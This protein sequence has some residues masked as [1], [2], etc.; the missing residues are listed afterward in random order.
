[1]RGFFDVGQLRDFDE[2][3]GLGPGPYRA[4]YRS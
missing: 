2:R 4:V 3:F 1:M